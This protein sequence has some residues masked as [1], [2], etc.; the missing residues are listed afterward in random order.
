[1]DKD[2][3]NSI[4]IKIQ[5]TVFDQNKRVSMAFFVKISEKIKKVPMRFYEPRKKKFLARLSECSLVPNISISKSRKA[6]LNK[7]F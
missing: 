5:P 7:Q 3:I 1:M 4:A 2:Q 6:Y